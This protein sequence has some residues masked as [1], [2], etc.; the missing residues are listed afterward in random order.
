M[1][2]D[3][4]PVRY[5]PDLKKQVVELQ[6]HLWSPSQPLNTAYFEWKYERNPYLPEPLVYLMMHDGQAIGMRGFFGVRW[7]AGIPALRFTGLYADDMV[8]AP[9]H[10]KR[11]LASR[12]MAFA[13]DDLAKQK[14]EYAFNLSAG[15]ETFRSSLSMGWRS[16]GWMQPMRWRSWQTALGSGVGQLVK[17][18]P[19]VSRKL[20]SLGLT[21]HEQSLRS[22][23][24]K[25]VKRIRRMFRAPAAVSVQ[26]E[27]RC[28]EM[29]QLVERIENRG[30]IRH[31]KD[32]EYLAWRFQNPLSR[33]QFIFWDEDR[34]EGYLVLQE[35][36]S[37]SAHRERVNIVDWEA[38]NEVVRARLLQSAI[39]I[40]QGKRLVIWAATM[41]PAA[42]AIL[43]CNGFKSLTRPTDSGPP[44]LLVRPLRQDQ[45]NASW[46]LAGRPLLDLA[47][48]DL[49]MLCS[50]LG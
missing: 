23:A 41:P 29:A 10:R 17:R 33:Y 11:G 37:E 5:R 27:P 42:I 12:V 9:D 48:W 6:T 43:E 19:A 26:N 39:A 13:F 49:P 34:L 50:M 30:R 14:F 46:M 25:D 8:I 7:E 24:D 1:A 22:L 18:L 15:P 47:S 21:R 16:A 36:A 31:V 4:E 3:Y 45:L 28:E 32:S 38:S 35:Y 44:A 20:G 2:T 40:A